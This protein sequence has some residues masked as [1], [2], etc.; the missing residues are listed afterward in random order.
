MCI[1]STWGHYACE[2]M[3]Q[4]CKSQ[5]NILDIY[6]LSH[7]FLYYIKTYVQNIFL[8][9]GGYGT[10]CLHML[11]FLMHATFSLVHTLG[12]FLQRS[13]QILEVLI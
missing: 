1:G 4:L 3:L 6:S 5:L 10:A 12:H 13:L 7:E 9:S 8:L 2:I 11:N